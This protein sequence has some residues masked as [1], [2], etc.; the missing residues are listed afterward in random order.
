MNRENVIHSYIDLMVNGRLTQ[1]VLGR[2][3]RSEA[4]VLG[5]L[6]NEVVLGLDSSR[7]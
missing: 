3:Y 6:P 4:R 2:N 7:A 1:W 5:W